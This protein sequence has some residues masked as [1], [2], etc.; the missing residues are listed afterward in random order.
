MFSV[1]KATRSNSDKSWVYMFALC[2]G[3]VNGVTPGITLPWRSDLLIGQN[4]LQITAH[5]YNPCQMKLGINLK[6]LDS[7]AINKS[8]LIARKQ[9]HGEII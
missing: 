1:P 2:I 5:I 9:K 8:S 3:S 6:T 4:R 7:F